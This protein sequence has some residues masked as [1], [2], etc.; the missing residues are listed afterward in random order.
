MLFT[1]NHYT[2]LNSGGDTSSLFLLVTKILI[3][4]F[5]MT[6]FNI[7][8]IKKKH[9]LFKK[10]AVLLQKSEQRYRIFDEFSDNVHF[11]AD[12]C[13]DRISFNSNF[14]CL[15][16]QQPGISKLSEWRNLLAFISLDDLQP[17]INAWE[18][19]LESCQQSS[20]DIRIIDAA[21]QLLWFRLSL[22]AQ[23]DGSGKA[24]R[25]LGRLTNI[26]A[27][28]RQLKRLRLKSMQDPLTRLYH[29]LASES[30]V[31]DFLKDEGKRGKHAMLI[32]NV[33]NIKAVND[34]FGQCS[35]DSVFISLSKIMKKVFRSSDIIGRL[36]GDEF[37]V[38]MK[39]IP[40][41]YIL[42]YKISA[43]IK[44]VSGLKVD[45]SEN[46][47]VSCSHGAAFYGSD[48]KSFEELYKAAEESLYL[49]KFKGT[50]NL[51]FSTFKNEKMLSGM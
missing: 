12:I 25:M 21:G 7:I 10:E 37:M 47:L 45:G 35:S 43:F 40:G 29:R 38:F 28:V 27:Q 14:E 11:D 39:D 20:A 4:F 34:R 33:D 23:Y 17:I 49:T 8:Q 24:I 18:K 41:E 50:N 48:G 26:D 13:E 42:E 51:G 30:L 22:V 31:D 5:I 46:A 3:I 44:A 15:F 1:A 6:F 2:S 16:G 32:I 19:A 9:A 36:G